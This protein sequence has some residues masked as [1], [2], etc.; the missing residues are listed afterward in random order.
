MNGLP[1]N[2]Q[3][4][5]VPDATVL[6]GIESQGGRAILLTQGKIAIVDAE[7]YEWLAK[8]HWYAT[9]NKNAGKYYAE[10]NDRST[11]RRIRVSMHRAIL[12][13][14]DKDQRMG[15]HINGNSLDNRR[16]NLRPATRSLNAYN[17]KL[18]SN[19]KS[20]FR[21]VVW[22]KSRRT[23]T[24]KILVDGKTRNLGRYSDPAAAA[25][26]FDRAAIFYRGG[27]AILNFPDRLDHIGERFVKREG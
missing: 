13:M 21:G 17:C 26:A 18:Y 25:E 4:R 20:S 15:D 12:G 8:H 7:D 24:A 16:F 6:A 3:L 14:E 19:N 1:G 11:G 23:W 27:T 9:Y 2:L 22:D 5:S 10:R